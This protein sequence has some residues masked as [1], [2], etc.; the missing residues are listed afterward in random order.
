[1]NY[2]NAGQGL[3]AVREFKASG[4]KA[5]L[6]MLSKIYEEGCGSVEANAMMAMKY[7]KEANN[8]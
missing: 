5:S 1:M 4:S 6:L 8:K 2:Y 7:R 3:E